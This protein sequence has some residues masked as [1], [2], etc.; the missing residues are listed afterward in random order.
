M[1]AV[2]SAIIFVN[3]DLTNQA[4]SFIV[5]QL[6]ISEVI[7]GETFD[8]RVAADSEYVNKVKQLGLR[9]LVVR[10]FVELTNRE[11]AD[12]V[13]FVKN[14]MAAV[15]SGKYGPPTKSFLVRNLYWGQLGIFI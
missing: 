5:T 15:E 9:L 8:A 11:L 7:P 14:G 13:I 4:Q 1:V 12:I 2:P 6:H 3:N 10:S